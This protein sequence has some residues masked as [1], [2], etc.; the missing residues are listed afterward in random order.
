MGDLYESYRRD[1]GRL[2][3]EQA[4]QQQALLE[5]EQA[6]SGQPDQE[7]TGKKTNK[8]KQYAVE[9]EPDLNGIAHF[10]TPALV[11]SLAN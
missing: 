5:A 4:I 6:T 9:E 2:E 1:K 10:H 11:K 3:Y 8:S 7:D